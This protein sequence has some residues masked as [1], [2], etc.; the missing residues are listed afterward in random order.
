MDLCSL[1]WLSRYPFWMG[2]HHPSPCYT[3][4]RNRTLTGE[5]YSFHFPFRSSGMKGSSK[6]RAV[7][8]EITVATFGSVMKWLHCTHCS[9]IT[10]RWITFRW[11]MTQILLC[12]S[13]WEEFWSSESRSLCA[14]PNRGVLC[15]L[16]SILILLTQA[17]SDSVDLFHRKGMTDFLILWWNCANVHQN[18]LIDQM[19][20]FP[21]HYILARML[22]SWSLSKVIS[23]ASWLSL[24]VSVLSL[25]CVASTKFFGLTLLRFLVVQIWYFRHFLWT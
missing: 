13:A 14:S 12:W 11:K 19:A 1:I 9:A 25:Q 8:V 7:V 21:R 17:V 10:T 4:W 20:Y 3:Q 22:V 16:A 24:L 15:S 6:E 2:T 18:Y 5:K 23:V